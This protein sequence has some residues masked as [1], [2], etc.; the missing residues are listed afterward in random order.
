MTGG[1]TGHSGASAGV[2]AGAGREYKRTVTGGGTPSKQQAEAEGQRAA[3]PSYPAT[4]PPTFPLLSP[5][6][7]VISRAPVFHLHW[8]VA[9]AATA[10]T[11]N[12]TD[13][14]ADGVDKSVSVSAGPPLLQRRCPLALSLCGGFPL[15]IARRVVWSGL[16]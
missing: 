14:V 11:D 16:I 12:A 3:V 13:G 8:T 2:S 7:D 15:Q 9:A 4:T 5:F 6:E 10:A 1:V